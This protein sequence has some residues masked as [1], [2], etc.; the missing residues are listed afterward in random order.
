MPF[1]YA[2]F[3]YHLIFSL[4]FYGYIIENGG[5]ALGYWTLQADTSQEAQSWMQ[6]F[7]LNTF[8]I[9]WLNYIPSKILGI[10]FWLGN[11]LYGLMTA[12]AW[13]VFYQYVKKMDTNLPS[14]ALKITFLMPNMHFWTAGVTKESLIWLFLVLFFVHMKMEKKNLFLLGLGLVGMFLIRPLYASFLLVLTI[15]WGLINS[16]YPK[17]YTYGAIAILL[18]FLG[19]VLWQNLLATHLTDF[20]LSSLQAYIDFQMRF[21]GDFQASSYVP[22]EN[23]SFPFA[24]F[25]FLFRP[26][27]WEGEGIFFIF[28]GIENILALALVV[29]AIFLAIWK[30]YRRQE[31][32]LV[33][34]MVFMFLLGITGS[35]VLNNFG[36]ILRYK[37]VAMIFLYLW[38]INSVFSV[39]KLILAKQMTK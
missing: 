14:W 3:L 38:A 27:P 34:G 24:L 18:V 5:D 23:Y 7:G 26:F 9:Q 13:V 39:L 29:S 22:M 8:F 28:A 36:I 2:L 20:N 25:T 17:K 32:F 1:R 35:L 4:F 12:F 10:T 11:L 33:Y 37:S 16:T 30:R 31:S 21:L 6:Y 15:V 19:L